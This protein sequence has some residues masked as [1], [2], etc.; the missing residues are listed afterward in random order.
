MPFHSFCL[1]DCSNLL[2]I[3]LWHVRSFDGFCLS[4]VVFFWKD[5]FSK[6]IIRLDG[7]F[8]TVF[9]NFTAF[10]DSLF[11][12]NN[13][14]ISFPDFSFNCFLGSYDGFAFIAVRLIFVFR[15]VSIPIQL[16]KFTRWRYIFSRRILR[17]Y[18]ISLLVVGFQRSCATYLVRIWSILW[19]IVYWRWIHLFSLSH[20]FWSALF[21]LLS[22]YWLWNHCFSLNAFLNNNWLSSLWNIELLPLNIFRN[23]N[24]LSLGIFRNDNGLSLRLNY[25]LVY[26]KWLFSLKLWN[27]C[28]LGVYNLLRLFHK[29]L[30]LWNVAVDY[31][32]WLWVDRFHNRL[33][34][35]LIIPTSYWCTF[36]LYRWR[37][38]FSHFNGKSTLQLW[39]I[40]IISFDSVS[41]QHDFV[42]SGIILQDLWLDCLRVLVETLWFE[43]LLPFGN[44]ICLCCSSQL[45]RHHFA[46]ERF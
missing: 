43:K 45:F 42:F 28:L 20:Y 46:L 1:S 21:G 8:E 30:P 41:I 17:N 38:S 29:S 32:L 10:L 27:I 40:S 34:N 25:W 7:S 11:L 31:W 13:F 26:Q 39:N 6:F 5:I 12:L 23:K 16:F 18:W 4:C 24:G 14:S 3:A 36:I 2:F 15:K 19:L 22:D 35:C 33:G 9:L 44:R 37:Y